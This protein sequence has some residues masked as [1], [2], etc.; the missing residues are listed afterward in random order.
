M[1]RTHA[2]IQRL[3]DRIGATWSWPERAGAIE[4]DQVDDLLAC[5]YGLYALLRLH[6][7]Q[8]EE[9]YFTLAEDEPPPRTPDSCQAL[10]HKLSR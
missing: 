4:P 7:V 3:A 10:A 5:L 1:S 8:E 6:F 2:E 9:N